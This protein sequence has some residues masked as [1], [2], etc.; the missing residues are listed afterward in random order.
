MIQPK[1]FNVD[2]ENL[3]LK[4]EGFQLRLQ[5]RFEVFEFENDVNDMLERLT[6]NIKNTAMEIAVGGGGAKKGK[7]I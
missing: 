5:N 3:Y 6:K 1:V 4:Q 7:K 2:I